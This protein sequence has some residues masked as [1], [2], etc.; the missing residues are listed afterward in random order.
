MSKREITVLITYF[1]I[2]IISLV[3]LVFVFKTCVCSIVYDILIALLTGCIFSLPSSLIIILF[4][5]KREKNELN[6]LLSELLD[7]LKKD[8]DTDNN[9]Y[10]LNDIKLIKKLYYEI[11]NENYNNFYSYKNLINELL[12][13]IFSLC[14]CF[15]EDGFLIRN[16]DKGK[17]YGFKTLSINKLKEILD[18]N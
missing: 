14:S 2:A 6:E 10:Y 7:L 12:N 11:G 13:S 5:K 9:K 17:A 16:N 18:K 4:N 15:D 3:V 1:V 8:F